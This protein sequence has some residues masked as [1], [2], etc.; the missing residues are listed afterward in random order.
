MDITET[1]AIQI[2]QYFLDVVQV[3]TWIAFGL[4]VLIVVLFV[5]LNELRKK[6]KFQEELIERIYEKHYDLR[7]AFLKQ[8]DSDS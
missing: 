3:A 4:F 6:V 2:S 8:L 5:F 1:I 7:S